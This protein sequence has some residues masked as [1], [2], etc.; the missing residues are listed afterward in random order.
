MVDNVNITE[1]TRK[2]VSTDEVTRTVVGEQMQI[3]K[4]GLGNDGVFD[5]LVAAG[6]QVEATSIPVVRSSNAATFE[7]L[8][9]LAF[10]SI[11]AGYSLLLTPSGNLRYIEIQNDTDAPVVISF[12]VGVTDHWHIPLKEPRIFDVNAFGAYQLAAIH[13]KHAGVAPTVGNVRIMGYR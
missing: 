5:N 8:T 1:G 2:T 11:G 6:D 7:A 10:G 12:D 13:I 3:I 9:S 4:L